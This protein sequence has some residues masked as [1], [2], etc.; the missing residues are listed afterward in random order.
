ML[1]RVFRTPKSLL[2]FKN[3]FYNRSKKPYEMESSQQR[4]EREE[5]RKGFTHINIAIMSFMF[6]ICFAGIPLYRRFCE[7]MG[8]TGDQ[9]K[10]EYD[11][12]DTKSKR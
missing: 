4:A 7:K 3:I 5:D 2:N 8:L 11:F 6:G 9:D 1:S 12:A 10:K